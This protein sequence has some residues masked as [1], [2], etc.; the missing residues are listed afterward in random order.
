VKESLEVT[1][2]PPS[3]ILHERP[4]ALRAPRRSTRPD[5]GDAFT[6]IPVFFFPAGIR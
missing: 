3:D 5:G 4:T 1:R 6:G 2:I